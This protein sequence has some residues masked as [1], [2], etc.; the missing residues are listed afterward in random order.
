MGRKPILK[1][2]NW[3]FLFVTTLTVGA[4]TGL[5]CGF[6]TYVLQTG[7]EVVGR[8]LWLSIL[9]FVGAGLMFSLMSQMGLFAYFF[10]QALM[11]GIL[12]RYWL[13]QVFQAV[14]VLL[15]LVDLVWLRAAAGGGHWLAYVP[16][17]LALLAVGLLVAVL[18]SH[19]TD[20]TAF[21]PTLFVMVVLTTLEW[22][23]ALT[24]G[25][26]LS[27][28]V[29]IVP[30]LCCNAWQVLILHRLVDTGKGDG[31]KTTA[32]RKKKWAAV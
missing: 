25:N 21:I 15:V 10:F 18:K 16:L 3:A 6:G 22:L 19:L 5:L 14:V 2:R 13:W 31:K 32:A 9:G 11:L 8:D 4:V 12:K 27:M 23:P 28:W 7:A 26:R 17:P 30:L 1:A 24:T 29:M 20:R